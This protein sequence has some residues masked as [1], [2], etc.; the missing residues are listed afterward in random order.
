MTNIAQYHQQL[1][2]DLEGYGSNTAELDA[3]ML[4]CH[5]LNLSL[6]DFILN[7][8][9]L[10]NQAQIAQLQKAQMLAKQQMPISRILATREFWGL[11]FTISPDVLDPRADSEILIETLQ[12]FLPNKAQNLSFLDLGTGSGCLLLALLNDY[13]NAKGLAADYSPAALK[14]AKQNAK[15]LLLSDRATF[16]QSDW[17]SNIKPQ[18]FDVIISNPPY[19]RKADIAQLAENVKNYD[20]NLALDGGQSGLEPYHIIIKNAQHYL[21]KDG[22]LILEMGHDQAD[23]LFKI[24]H[25]HGFSSNQFNPSS[26]VGQQQND[27]NRSGLFYDLGQNPRCII[28]KHNK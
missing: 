12:H 21:A 1:T 6:T 11:E 15:N 14:I 13:K 4:I 16:I 20:P 23:E 18:E 28:A 8:H 19:I 9:D 26:M 3:R 27:Q 7:Q 24:L 10:V 2:N 22:I 17:F 5:Y 25:Q